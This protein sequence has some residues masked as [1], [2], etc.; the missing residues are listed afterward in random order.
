MKPA[1]VKAVSD[2]TYVVNSRAVA[3]AMLLSRVLEPAKVHGF[4]GRSDKHEA[5]ART[6]VTEPGHGRNG[7]L[8]G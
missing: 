7:F 2:G 1:L 4:A 6:D 3:E 5:G 8:N